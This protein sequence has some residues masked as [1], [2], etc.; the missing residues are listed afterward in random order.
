MNTVNFEFLKP[1]WEAL[2]NIAGFAEQ[3]VHADPASSLVKLRL[4]C[5]QVVEHI[6]AHHRFSKPFQAGLND[7]LQEYTF[8]QAVPRVVLNK[9]HS[10]R[11]QG[12]K[13]AHGEEVATHQSRWI[14][15]EA[16]DL[17]KWLVLTYGSTDI[18]TL[19]KYNEPEPPSTRDPAELRK[20]K[21]AILERLAKSEAQTDKLL[22]ELDAERKKVKKSEATTE[23]LRAA[24][25]KG[26]QTANKL[27][28]NEA[29]T[30]K[31]LIDSQLIGAGWDVGDDLTDTDQVKQE[32]K[33]VYVGG[34]EGNGRADYALCRVEDERVLAVVEA[35]R[36][37]EDPE[38]GREQA[39]M[40]ADAIAA[41]QDG[42]RPII[43]LSLIHIS[44]PTRPY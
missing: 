11:V 18:S 33:V 21:K 41:T 5:E 28:F 14:L 36:T 8:K 26:Q 6:Y 34:D 43:F 30:R 22:K 1:N 9:L 27:E 12:N 20:E 4:F 16:F 23:E 15:N 19:P 7:L 40:Y 37:S 13:A 29:T 44:E 3:Y 32:F 39:R 17:A 38:V 2:A 35:K 10:L 24:A 31:R 42:H 25:T